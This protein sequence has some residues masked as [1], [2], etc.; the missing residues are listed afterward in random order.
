MELKI[1]IDILEKK[2]DRVEDELRR[3]KKMGNIQFPIF[4]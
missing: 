2:W 3:Y 1:L 4:K